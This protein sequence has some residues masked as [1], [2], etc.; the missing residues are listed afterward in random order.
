MDESTNSSFEPEVQ[1]NEAAVVNNCFKQNFTNFLTNEIILNDLYTCEM[2]NEKMIL[3]FYLKEHFEK[4]LENFINK[5]PKNYVSNNFL[6]FVKSN[7][8][9]LPRNEMSEILEKA[10]YT[11]DDVNNATAA[12]AIV[13]P[14]FPTEDI[15]IRGSV[16]NNIRNMFS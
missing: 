12:D 16:G 11:W 9:I 6:L 8:T 4:C 13:L 14:V 15:Y 2:C 7:L 10:G 1:Q 5:K 3:K